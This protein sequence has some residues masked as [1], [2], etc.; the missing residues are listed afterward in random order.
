MARVRGIR[1]GR[2]LRV[3]LGAVALT[4]LVAA[5]CTSDDAASGDDG[6][7][8]TSPRA[9]VEL[10]DALKEKIAALV[11]SELGTP[12]GTVGLFVRDDQWVEVYGDATIPTP[13][14]E[15]TPGVESVDRPV[16][17]SA[18][19]VW[20]LRSIT[21]SF[22]VTL[23]LQLVEEG[24]VSLDDT[25]EQY[26]PGLPNGDE[27]TLEQLA[28]MTSGLPEYTNQ[29]WVDAFS[30][31]PLRLFTAPELIGFAADEPAQF[32]PGAEH[33]YTNTNT[34]VL[35]QVIEAVGGAPFEEQLRTRILEPL[36]LGSTVYPAGV[37]DWNGPH[38]TGYQMDGDVLAPQIVNF[39]VFDTAGA[40]ISNVEDLAVWG[41]ALATGSLV[42]EEL[43]D[44]RT[45]VA[46][47]LDEGP[48]Y[49][50]YGLGI[51]EIDGWWGHT[52]EGMGYEALVMHDVDRDLTVVIY[53]N[54]SNITDSATGDPVH[55]PTSL[56]R[57]IAALLDGE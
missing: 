38:A 39:S 9:E 31:D 44:E 18:D 49:D 52:G 22:T 14:A 46:A 15:A 34:V 35:G 6:G 50:E 54:M 33:V 41:E 2:S 53:V 25:V 48:E 32:D 55:V 56:F 27:I 12:G 43:Q 13:D 7:T 40:M 42:T 19:M 16:P 17:V 3:A 4:A 1:S 57:K 20:P 45:S 8:T 11:E 51:G 29:A 21:K 37:A 36:A 23:L 26:V 28:A 47:P 10:D 5:G 30:A 24:L